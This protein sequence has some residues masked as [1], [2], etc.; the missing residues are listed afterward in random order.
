MRKTR[1]AITLAG[2]LTLSLTACG[3]DGKT[4]TGTATSAVATNTVAPPTAPVSA[5]PNAGITGATVQ[6]Q[7]SSTG[8]CAQTK[9]WSTAPRVN[10]KSRADGYVTKVY[11]GESLGCDDAATFVVTTTKR[12][13]NGI[14]GSRVSYV[15]R[16]QVVSEGREAPLPNIPQ[17][18]TV[19]LRVAVLALGTTAD[20]QP[21]W[22][23]GEKVLEPSIGA[24]AVVKGVWYAGSQEGQSLFYIGAA[25]KRAFQI[26]NEVGPNRSLV[27]VRLAR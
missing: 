16:D 1:L 26:D 25:S 3:S 21:T 10:D 13:D 27:I 23:V 7:S 9:T 24:D 14:T 15:G 20:S 18:V 11:R 5:T 8:A 2:L 4:A 22:S 6:P 19:F 12:D 17:S